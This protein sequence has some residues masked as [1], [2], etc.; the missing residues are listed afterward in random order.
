[1]QSTLKGAS[2]TTDLPQTVKQKSQ[3]KIKSHL[4]YYDNQERVEVN[5]L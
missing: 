3:Q 5:N 1:M 4:K 2:L